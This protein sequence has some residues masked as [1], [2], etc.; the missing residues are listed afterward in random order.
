M[1]RCRAARLPRQPD[2]SPLLWFIPLLAAFC[3]VAL[4]RPALSNGETTISHGI[5]IF[6]DLKYPADFPHFD[7]VNPDAPKGGTMRFVGT[8]ASTTFDSVNPFILK[9]NAAQGL[10]RLYDTLLVGSADE[11]ASAYGLV[12]QTIEY[13][14]DRAWV[15]FEMNP[16]A[17]FSDGEP[18]QASDV[19]FSHRIL[20]EQG[21][22]VYKIQYQDIA[23]VEALGPHTVKF[24][25]DP[26]APK[27][28]LIQLAGSISILP[29]H[30]YETV[31]FDESTL[32]PPVGSG[33]YLI[34]DIDA[35]RSVTYCRNP[36][37]WAWDHPVN[38]GANNFDC[39]I[40]EYFTD[41]TVAFE[42]FKSGAY[43]LQESFSSKLW[44]TAYDFPAIDDGWVV[45]TSIADNRPSG[46]QGF[47]INLRRDK[48]DDPR[49]R[50]A[51][52]MMFN[53]EFSN[54]ALFY[55]IYDRTDSFWEN[56]DTMQASGLPEG[57]ELEVL[58]A[59]RDQLPERIFTEPA[60]TPAINNADRMSRSIIRRAN[61]LLDEAGWT[62]QDG[63]R[64][65]AEG[66]TLVVELVDDSPAFE[67][68]INPYIENLKRIGVDARLVFV[69]PA[70]ME[71]RQKDRDYD[72]I[73]GR[74]VMS[75]TPG[76]ELRQF[77][78]SESAAA[79]DTLNLAG[80][81]DPVVDALIE[82]IIA[83]ETRES[84]EAHVRALD[85]VLRDMHV[86]VPN[87][88][89]GEHNIAYW[90]I[91]GRPDEKPPYSRGDAYWW[92]DQER[93]D[94]LKAAGAPLP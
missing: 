41:R 15:I 12:A 66:Q 64:K 7:Y 46:T 91:F 1:L 42:A 48:F 59:F 81:A 75:L 26:D 56:T 29:E 51:L 83:A 53:F 47:W 72:M 20:V 25:F 68:I 49:V 21:H 31:P 2:V 37:Y 57:E 92:F 18:I 87:W 10:A 38:V 40:Y 43:Y 79:A 71:Q 85:R 35:G 32:T 86:W 23:T 3:I 19:V 94:T 88:Y 13:P 52:G 61:A 78:G 63:L 9:G 80:I 89:K 76:L 24:T 69:D 74:L 77:Y 4:A 36:D 50:E 11:P 67:R 82:R 54:K 70:Q 6:G 33:G 44:A 22:P 65:N 14:E 27:R 62:L 45:K 16:E 60:F 58:E 8:A 84:M 17:T 90:D 39:I 93:Y 5:S 30:Y 55:G 34:D 73:P 28:E